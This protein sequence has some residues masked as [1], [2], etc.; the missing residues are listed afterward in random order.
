[1]APVRTHFL[2][3]SDMK[4]VAGHADCVTSH[5]PKMPCEYA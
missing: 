5:L 3:E 2:Q 4:Q 1:M